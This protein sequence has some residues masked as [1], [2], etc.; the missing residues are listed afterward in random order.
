MPLY[1]YKCSRCSKEFEALR[2]IEERNSAECPECSSLAELQ[3]SPFAIKCHWDTGPIPV[4]ANDLS[5]MNVR[6]LERR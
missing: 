1:R 3:L 4:T 2:S 5:K 6:G